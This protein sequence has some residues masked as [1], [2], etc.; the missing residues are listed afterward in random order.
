MKW[1]V[2]LLDMIIWLPLKLWPTLFQCSF[3]PN[4][5]YEDPR[6]SH[7]LKKTPW[8]IFFNIFK[9][10]GDTTTQFGDLSTLKI[11]EG[12]YCWIQIPAGENGHNFAFK[13]AYFLFEIS[14]LQRAI[15][16][17]VLEIWTHC[18]YLK[19]SSCDELLIRH[20]VLTI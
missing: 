15:T 9:K 16:S 14:K 3:H 1:S 10:I 4:Y 7:V 17:W 20:H 19:W 18:K 13:N 8:R 6:K 12:C 2:E 11:V 5:P